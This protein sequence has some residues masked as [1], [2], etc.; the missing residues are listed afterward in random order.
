MLTLDID[1]HAM[2]LE[3]LA[4]ARAAMHHDLEE[5]EAHDPERLHLQLTYLYEAL[6]RALEVESAERSA[7]RH[8]IA[9]ALGIDENSGEW[10]A[11]A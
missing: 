11:G 9:E 2:T 10:L 3:E 7:E 6:E 5:A 4:E 1:L 8:V